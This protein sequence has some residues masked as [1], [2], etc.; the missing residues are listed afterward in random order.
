MN[1]TTGVL[2]DDW[3]NDSD[4]IPIGTENLERPSQ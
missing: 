3:W 4:K 2:T 1:K